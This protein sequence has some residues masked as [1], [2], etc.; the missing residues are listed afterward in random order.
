MNIPDPWTHDNRKYTATP[1]AGTDA[2]NSRFYFTEE[3]ARKDDRNIHIFELDRET[4]EWKPLAEQNAPMLDDEEYVGKGGE[5]C[6]WCGSGDVE[7]DSVDADGALAWAN[8]QCGACKAEWTD[9]FNLTGYG[10]LKL[11]DGRHFQD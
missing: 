10:Q 11:P 8:V 9:Q 6:P 5:H 4:G 7:S 3:D 2:G 1:F